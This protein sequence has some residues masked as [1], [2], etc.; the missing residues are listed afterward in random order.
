MNIYHVS[1]I[2][3]AFA[4]LLDTVNFGPYRLDSVATTRRG[5]MGRGQINIELFVKLRIA[6]DSV[7]SSDLAQNLLAV[8]T[9]I[10]R[11]CF[12]FYTRSAV[13]VTPKAVIMA[14]GA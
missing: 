12:E 4:M 14:T 10:K 6:D 13:L 7:S 11:S 1:D 8:E 3:A 5:G 2:Q 9:N